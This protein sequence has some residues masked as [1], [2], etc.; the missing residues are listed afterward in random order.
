[1][2]KLELALS[3]AALLL[4]SCST[5]R[6]SESPQAS[7][8]QVR[9]FE[10]Q[11]LENG[12][13][14]LW[15]QDAKIPVVSL[16]MAL[17]GGG[18]YD[19]EGR[20]GLADLTAQLLDKGIQGKGAMAIA[21]GLE[22]RA[23]AF[24]ASVDSDATFVGIRGLSFHAKDSLKD[25]F[26]LVVHPTFPKDEVER[27]RKLM[28][29]SLK[30]LADRPGEF[31]NLVYGRVIYGDHPY[32]HDG[33]GTL[34]GI[35]RVTRDDI[36][37]YH[38]QYYSPDRAT[39]AVV[40]QY[41]DEFRKSVIQTFSQWKKSSVAEVA[42]PQPQAKPG[43]LI[44]EVQKPDLQQTEI[45]M[46]HLGVKRNIP[47]HLALKVATAILGDPS[48]FQARLW[49]EI[50]VKRGL[51]YGVRA[52]FDQRLEPGPFVIT[53]FTRND[54]IHEMVDQLLKVFKEFREKGATK[55]EVEAAK[56]QL[57]GRFPRLVE[58]G[59]D[60]AHQ[61]L[62]LDIDGV[63]FEYLRTFQAEIDKITPE[64]V[65]TAIRTHFQPDNLKFVVFGPEGSKGMES[66][67]EFGPVTVENYKKAL[68][69]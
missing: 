55:D 45:R 40:G 6:K 2:R 38:R 4:S 50:R 5:A 23:D 33:T 25:F 59:D 26:Q 12:M 24:G 32:A 35:A 66:L 9:P 43:L 65:N 31:A 69:M 21:D 15:I 68:E 60:L 49:N 34:P 62:L 19:P 28:L 47:D 22:Q 51:T 1:M 18:S 36:A 20:E 64:D 63:P 58:T 3:F 11:T 10:Q 48:S 57:R 52:A 13:K 42:I 16:A 56:A 29:A 37:K 53:T 67:K 61:L 27:E 41:D 46:G 30:R 17:K 54:K 7:A 39:L 14:I 8:F 44:Y